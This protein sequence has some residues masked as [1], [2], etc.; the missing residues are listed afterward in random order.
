MPDD[1][2]T[3]TV[4]SITPTVKV[5]TGGLPQDGFDVHFVT[6]TAIE[7]SVFVAK[8]QVG[9]TAFV[10]RQVADAVSKLHAIHSLSG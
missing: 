7:G 3:W 8:A 9:D 5:A 1:T 2:P 4:N 6:S 10:A